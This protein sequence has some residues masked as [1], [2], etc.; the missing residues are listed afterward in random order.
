MWPLNRVGFGGP[1]AVG[2]QVRLLVDFLRFG[3]ERFADMCIPSCFAN[4]TEALYQNIHAGAVRTSLHLLIVEA[5]R[6]RAA[7]GGEG[8]CQS[9]LVPNADENTTTFIHN[10]S[11][12]ASIHR[13]EIRIPTWVG[14]RKYE[15][16]TASRKS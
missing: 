8:E 5:A 9:R 11:L 7:R 4:A 1:L 3:D 10:V 2:L 15:L 16:N 12:L 6:L 13:K 14:G